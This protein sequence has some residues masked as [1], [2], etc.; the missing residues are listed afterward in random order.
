M[1]H[2]KT[3]NAPGSTGQ[4]YRAGGLY[5]EARVPDLLVHHNSVYQAL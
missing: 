5:L 3:T 4:I 1:K 2:Q